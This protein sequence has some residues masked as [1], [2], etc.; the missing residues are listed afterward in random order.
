[1]E[2]RKSFAK[3]PDKIEPNNLVEIQTK[4]YEGFFST[5]EAGKKN[6]YSLQAIF[7]EIFPIESTDG[8]CRLEYV[9]FSSG[10][11]RYDEDE[12][13]KRGVS[14]A[15]PLRVKL[16]FKIAQEVRE[17]EVYMGELPIMTKTG[18]FII[19]GADRVI[20]SQLHRSPGICF[21]ANIHPK[22]KK[23]YSARIIPYR[24]AWLEFGFD[25]NDILNVTIDRRKKILCT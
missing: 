6:D 21:E 17:Q 7:K 22:G 11:P 14:Y 3:I 9:R 5:G 15:A 16:R 23:L 18:T 24:G 4:S 1:M 2:K 19:N 10:K 25:I 13:R 20:V 12:S 8:S